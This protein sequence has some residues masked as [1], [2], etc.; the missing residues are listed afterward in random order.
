MGAY[1]RNQVLSAAMDAHEL[2]VL[3]GDFQAAAEVGYGRDSCNQFCVDTCALK[4]GDQA[5]RAA[6]E[7][8]IARQGH[9]DGVML[10]VILN[11]SQHFGRI[12]GVEQGL[13]GGLERIQH[14]AGA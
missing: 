13:A 3:P 8:H 14:A 12:I 2:H 11:V 1:R 5:L 9:C 7:A 10:R 4:G 6:V